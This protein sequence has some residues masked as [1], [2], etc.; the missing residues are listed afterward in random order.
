MA[1]A[2]APPSPG[3]FASRERARTHQAVAVAN[4]RWRGHCCPFGAPITIIARPSCSG[5]SATQD[6]VLTAL[7][8][9]HFPG[10]TSTMD[11]G[12]QHAPERS[13]TASAGS[14]GNSAMIA[15]CLPAVAPAGLRPP[16]P[17]E[18]IAALALQR[19]ATQQVVFSFFP[20]K[21]ASVMRL[22]PDLLLISM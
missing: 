19:E 2:A 12:T 20:Y 10:G 17:C 22:D 15:C 11:H 21:I 9:D 3:L 18:S 6:E 13:V 1:F 16:S 14:T 4:G 8:S 7:T 5:A